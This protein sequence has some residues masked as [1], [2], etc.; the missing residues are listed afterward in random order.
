MN[1]IEK[2]GNIM[3]KKIVFKII[4]LS[5]LSTL[6]FACAYHE[7]YPDEWAKPVI[8]NKDCVDISGTY[9]NISYNGTVYLSSFIENIDQQRI[10]EV[11]D[12]VIY[13]PAQNIISIT[14]WNENTPIAAKTYR[15][16]DFKCTDKGI[17]ISLGLE[18]E[19]SGMVGAIVWGKATFTTTEDG[20]LLVIS[21]ANLL[22]LV[23]PW[24]PVPGSGLYYSKFSLKEIVAPD[25]DY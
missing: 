19:Y 14:A 12:V 21:D 22:F 11:T 25:T 20:S 4:I 18:S 1:Q 17:E 7:K 8:N 5:S 13:Y 6:L 10:G 15:K 2:E 9:S 3:F 23:G 24:I 16:D